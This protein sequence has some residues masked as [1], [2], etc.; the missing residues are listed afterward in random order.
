MKTRKQS[1]KKLEQSFSEDSKDSLQHLLREE[2][3]EIV[4]DDDF[5]NNEMDNFYEDLE[6]EE[7][8][9]EKEREEKKKFQDHKNVLEKRDIDYVNSEKEYEDSDDDVIESDID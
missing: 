7:K 4:D 3:N 2:D 6:E 1:V 5:E 9:K 8:I